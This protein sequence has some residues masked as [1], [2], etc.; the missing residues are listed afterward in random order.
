[1]SEILPIDSVLRPK[2][3]KNSTKKGKNG[4]NPFLQT[5]ILKL[6][7]RPIFTIWAK[8]KVSF[9]KKSSVSFKSTY[10]T[11]KKKKKKKKIDV[12]LLTT[13]RTTV[14][15]LVLPTFFKK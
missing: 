11:K 2:N 4:K 15:A 7:H 12:K 9:F 1:V 8:K 3:G 6:L 5:K 10:K 13:N 14:P